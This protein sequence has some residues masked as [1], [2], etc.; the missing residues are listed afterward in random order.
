MIRRRAA[1]RDNE[2]IIDNAKEFYVKMT[3]GVVRLILRG[4]GSVDGAIVA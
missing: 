1:M 4:S 2:A 3:T